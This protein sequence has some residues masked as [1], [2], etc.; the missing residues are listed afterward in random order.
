MQYIPSALLDSGYIQRR[1]ISPQPDNTIDSSVFGLFLARLDPIPFMNSSDTLSIF[2]AII[3]KRPFPLSLTFALNSNG[4]PFYGSLEVAPSYLGYDSLHKHEIHIGKLNEIPAANP[5]HDLWGLGV[6]GYVQTSPF[7]GC[8]G[9]L[10]I[11]S[12]DKGLESPI[13]LGV[14]N[15][16]GNVNQNANTHVSVALSDDPS[17]YNDDIR[18]FYDR[19]CDNYRTL[20]A[21][22]KLDLGAGKRPQSKYSIDASISSLDNLT[23]AWMNTVYNGQVGGIAQAQ[24]LVIVS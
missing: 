24:A 17:A 16:I 4:A 5:D 7:W 8:G 20:T 21:Q 1:I 2:V 10:S 11:T 19:D 15:A 3:N 9:A 18:T 14:Q 6:V 13:W 23:P 12:T 22:A